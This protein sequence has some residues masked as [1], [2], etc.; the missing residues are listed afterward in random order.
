MFLFCAAYLIVEYGKNQAAQ[1]D[2][3][4]KKYQTIAKIIRNYEVCEVNYFWIEKLFDNLSLCKCRNPEM[5][6][7]L[8][9]EFRDKYKSVTE[10]QGF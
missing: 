2:E 7:V 4:V 6:E 8:Y 9:N 10:K 3:Y 1:N 5:T